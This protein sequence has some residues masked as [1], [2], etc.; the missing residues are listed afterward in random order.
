MKYH[1]NMTDDQLKAFIRVVDE[2]HE[3]LTKAAE[4]DAQHSY[5]PPLEWEDEMDTLR[6][7]ALNCKGQP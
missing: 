1:D 2:L 6:R 7:A 3:A 4:H 5:P